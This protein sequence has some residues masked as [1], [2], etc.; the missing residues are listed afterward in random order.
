MKKSPFAL[1]KEA[2]ENELFNTQL[3][4]QAHTMNSTPI[5]AEFYIGYAEALKFIA[6]KAEFIQRFGKPPK[7]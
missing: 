3:Q 6:Q 7:F 5:N 4:L 1:L 2:I